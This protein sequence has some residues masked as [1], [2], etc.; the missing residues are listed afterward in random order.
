MKDELDALLKL[1]TN[2]K[3]KINSKSQASVQR[4]RKK[5][6]EWEKVSK[7]YWEMKKEVSRKIIELRK[8]LIR[9][10]EIFEEYYEEFGNEA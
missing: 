6:G 5:V 2:L 7:E 10:T 4:L 9:K 3:D 1:E 8:L